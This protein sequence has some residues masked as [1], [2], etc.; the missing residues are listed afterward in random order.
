MIDT[1]IVSQEIQDKLLEQVRK[2]QQTV[3]DAL[4]GAAATA[5]GIAP[6]RPR[7]AWAARLPKPEE[8]M[9]SA[10]DFAG[11]W[12]AAQRKSSERLLAAQKKFAADALDAVRP[13]LAL[14]STSHAAPGSKPGTVKAGSTAKAGGSA[15]AGSTVRTSGDAKASGTSKAGSNGKKS[16]G[17]AGK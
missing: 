2:G 8:L 16:G 4:R 13:L 9:A 1:R 11:Q 6:Q 12:L 5:Q 15:K 17:T 7:P 10:Q 3:A 14:A